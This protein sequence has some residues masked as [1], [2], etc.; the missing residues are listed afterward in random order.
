[1]N[2]RIST[3]AGLEPYVP[4]Q[5]MPWN[6]QRASHL[7]RRSQMGAPR[8]KVL[9]LL[10]L[11]PTQSV[12]LI[13]G[14]SLSQPEFNR[15]EIAP[16][17]DN[18]QRIINEH[19]ITFLLTA[20]LREKMTLFWSNLLIASL[21]GYNND[22]YF[23]YLS[24]LR[25]HALGNYK[26]LISKLGLNTAMIEYLDMDG[27]HKDGPNENYARE[28]LELFTMSPLNKQGIPN[29]SEQDIQEI[30]RAFTG[31]RRIDGVVDFYSGRFDEGEKTVFGR[32]GNW[33]YQDII[34][35]LF[36]ERTSEIAEY[37]CRKIYT[38]FVYEAPDQN[39]VDELALTFM[40]A[41]F[42]IIPVL[43]Q[44]FT[45]RHFYESNLMG[46]KIKSPCESLLGLMN[47]IDRGITAGD[48]EEQLETTRERIEYLGQPLGMPPDVFG[49]PEHDAWISV[50]TLPARWDVCSGLVYSNDGFPDYDP[51][52]L[53]RSIEN[54]NDPYILVDELV[55]I[56]LAIPPGDYT[57]EDLA[58]ILLDGIPDYEW[59]IDLPEAGI[60]IQGF[61][62]FL[63]SLPEFQLI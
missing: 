50:Q 43:Q 23:D 2:Q 35:I 59:N 10:S 1:M 39:V 16:D 18:P 13:I 12:N 19:W 44:L 24:L 58:E 25:E 29:Y 57:N 38:F 26:A 31:W 5:D 36:E 62:V 51:I 3:R 37:V 52:P 20:G 6:Y 28:L 53:I 7:L 42:E 14:E 40:Q 41:D 61:L 47:E 55:R 9:E 45:S 8:E 56:V 21:N 48:T 32:T 34:D 60:R 22:Y 27:S 63:T 4:D 30:A 15:P 46:A 33:G 17:E 11:T 49:W 54:H